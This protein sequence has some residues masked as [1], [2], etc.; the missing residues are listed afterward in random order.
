MRVT[1]RVNKDHPI[2]NIIGDPH[3]G[4]RTRKGVEL[5]YSMYATIK[6]TGILHT[7]LYNYFIS[8]VEPKNVQMALKE[9]TDGLKREF[10]G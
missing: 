10:M 7:C 5:S 4:V 1:T 9:C 8:Q 3:T 6:D 2:D